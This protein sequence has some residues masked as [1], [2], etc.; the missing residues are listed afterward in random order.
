METNLYRPF[1]VGMYPVVGVLA[2]LLIFDPVL[3]VG[4]SV[5]TA[6]GTTMTVGMGW[7]GVIAL[8]Y[9]APWTAAGFSVMTVT[10]G[11]Q[12]LSGWAIQSQ[13]AAYALVSGAALL[14]F[15]GSIRDTPSA[16]GIVPAGWE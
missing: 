9:G 12:T 8:A 1:T 3:M 14:W 15:I 13:F 11:Y 7:C 2:F 6:I 5:Q 16:P 4:V 10:F